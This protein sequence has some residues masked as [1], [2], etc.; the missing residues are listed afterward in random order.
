VSSRI[1]QFELLGIPTGST[2]SQSFFT[3]LNVD[4]GR[5][6]AGAVTHNQGFNDSALIAELKRDLPNFGAAG[7]IDRLREVVVEDT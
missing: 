7:E 5:I 3:D 1:A 2:T 6:G 4:L